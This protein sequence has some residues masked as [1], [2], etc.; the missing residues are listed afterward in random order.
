ML[1]I[2]YRTK[3]RLK[4]LGVFLGVS[5]LIAAVCLLCWMVWL[6]RYVVYTRE[7]VRFD[8]GRSTLGLSGE[9]A[10]QKEKV[11]A[12]TVAIDY[13]DGTEENGEPTETEKFSGYYATT[14]MLLDDVAGVRSAIEALPAGSAVMLDV[15]S[16]Y[17]NFYYSTS[18][19][20]ASK[21][22]A[23]DVAAVDDLIAYLR[24]GDY[25]VIAR[26]PAFCDLA[27]A[28]AHTASGLALESGVLW[29]DGNGCY[30]LDPNSEAVLAN[31]AQICR[32]L[33]ELGFD[34]VVF[35]HFYFPDNGAI[36]YDS[37]VSKADTIKNAA[38]QLSK[39]FSTGA[40]R[41]SFCAGSGDF[42]LPEGSSRLYLE[43]IHP[44]QAEAVA[45]QV[46]IDRV[47]FVTDSRDTRFD[48]A[49]VIRSLERED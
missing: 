14:Q 26:L 43:G 40:F 41:V 17:G 23:L 34:E 16:I 37:T 21:A 25:H 8:F 13:V 49:S 35:D 10:L 42:P 33:T 1:V 5:V 29:A 31:L 4:K 19:N 3:S 27:F 22:D 2:S 36:V 7:G 24:G 9:P 48:A 20:G 28:K 47:V 39:A 18:L 44:E 45:G 38:K 15:K 11:P 46:G 6:Q 12:E 32:E 30:W